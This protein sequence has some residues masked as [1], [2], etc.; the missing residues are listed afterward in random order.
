[1]TVKELK[2]KLNKFDDHLIVCIP[3]ENKKGLFPWSTEINLAQGV[4]EADGCLFI[5]N[6]VEEDDNED[7]AADEC[8]HEWVFQETKKSY[9]TTEYG[10]GWKAC[11]TRLDLYYCKHCCETKEVRKEASRSLP[12]GGVRCPEKHAPDWY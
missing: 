7:D 11:Y 9:F 6:F 4:N 12:F 5:D 1:M 3:D 10:S 8:K 2:D